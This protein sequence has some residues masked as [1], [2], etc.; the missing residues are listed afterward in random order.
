VLERRG[1]AL[2]GHGS[3]SLCVELGGAGSATSRYEAAP[4]CGASRYLGEVFEGV[5][6]ATLVAPV[7]SRLEAASALRALV[8]SGNL[9]LLA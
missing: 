5:D 9:S 7:G 6:A 1:E 3:E 8:A 2:E 4:G